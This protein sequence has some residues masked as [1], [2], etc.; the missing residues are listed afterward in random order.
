MSNISFF[1]SFSF[2]LL[3][4]FTFSQDSSSIRKHLDTLCSPHMHG[5]GY[6]NNGDKIAAEYIS[7]EFKKSGLKSFLF[8]TYQQPFPV[9][10]NTFPLV[11]VAFDKT[12]LIAGKDYLVL[13]FSSGIK[14]GNYKIFT[15]NKDIIENETSFLKFKQ[16]DFASGFILID[17]AGIKDSSKL[18]FMESMAHNPLSAKGI[19]LV[20]EEKLTHGLSSKAFDFAAIKILRTSLPVEYKKIS[21]EIENKFYEK[22]FTQNVVGFVEGTQ[23]PDSFLIFSAHYDHL[24]IMG[25]EC[26]FP[27][28]NDNASGTAM[29]L[30][31][32]EY[33]SRSPQKCSVAFISFGSE[34]AGLV[35]SKYFTQHPLFPLEKI[36]FLIN[37]DILGTGDEGITVVNAAEYPE[38][39]EMLKKSNAEKNLLPGINQ[40]GK[41]QNSDHYYFSE[42]GVPAFFI[43]TL[44]GIKAYHDIYDRPE[45]LPL[46][47]FEDVFN[48]LITFTGWL[49]Q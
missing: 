11:H 28:A 33:F 21:I 46:T 48:L 24:G 47:K 17:K 31:L 23:F 36:R 44:G 10:I 38:E 1:L 49:Q 14:K 41:A 2:F 22:Y 5:R 34:E 25:A 6:L 40:R 32:A 29:L 30:H 7:S 35:G 39:F 26:Y 13:P 37:L 4:F 8:E 45:T 19:I 27:G 3:T 9:A 20:E 16:Q 42:K 43:Y 18:K 12:N 15:L